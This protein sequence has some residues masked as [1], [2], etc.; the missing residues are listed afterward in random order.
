VGSGQGRVGMFR[1]K[2][3][4]N[5]KYSIK[6]L[7]DKTEDILRRLVYIKNCTQ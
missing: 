3:E 6:R 1:Q 2:V 5:T 4:Q 7:N